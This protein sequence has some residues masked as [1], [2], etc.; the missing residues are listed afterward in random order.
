MVNN[1][2]IQ[3]SKLKGGVVVTASY[4]TGGLEPPWGSWDEAEGGGVSKQ[5]SGI[6]P[7]LKTAQ[8]YY[9]FVFFLST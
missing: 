6:F 3:N 1:G 9:I 2:R 7:N 5:I 8:L 4:M